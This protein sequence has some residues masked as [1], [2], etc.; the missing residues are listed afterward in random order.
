[1]YLF[2]ISGIITITGKE[3]NESYLLIKVSLTGIIGCFVL[4]RQGLAVILAALELT[5]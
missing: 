1:M 4:L 2:D 3:E 5:I